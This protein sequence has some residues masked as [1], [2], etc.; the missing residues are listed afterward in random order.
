MKPRATPTPPPPHTIVADDDLKDPVDDS[1]YRSLQVRDYSPAF[2]G[3]ALSCIRVIMKNK[4]SG[5]V[6]PVK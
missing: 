2:P 5:K 4:R 3:T 6:R 1:G